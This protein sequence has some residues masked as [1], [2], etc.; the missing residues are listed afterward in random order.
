MALSR[1][2]TPTQLSFPLPALR[3]RRARTSP[4]S[5]LVNACLTSGISNVAW[6]AGVPRNTVRRWLQMS[7]PVLVARQKPAVTLRPVPSDFREMYI[8]HGRDDCEIVYR[9][10]HQ[11]ITRWLNETG[12]EELTRARAAYV[13][14]QRAKAR[15]AKP[16]KKKPA[17]KIK[18]GPAVDP[19]IAAAAAHHLR[20]YPHRYIVQ[21]TSDDR[22][23]WYVDG[24]GR[25][26]AADMVAF[27]T[28]RGFD[29]SPISKPQEVA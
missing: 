25:M 4:P 12:R 13:A 8:L 22:T 16:V 15:A 29:P 20:K 21:P 27:A 6:R 18:S 2:G 17:R 26:S 11:T 23:E 10:S 19:E 5:D 24:R 7:A 14:E 9:A 1:D 3:R 28:A